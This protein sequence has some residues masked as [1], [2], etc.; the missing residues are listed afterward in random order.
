MNNVYSCRKI[1]KLLRRDI[2]FIWLANYEKP[3]YITINRFR[4]RV[5]NELNEIFTLLVLL[6]AEKGFITLDVEYIDG[7]KLESRANKYTFW[8]KGVER[9]RHKLQEKIAVLLDQIDESVTQENA[10]QEGEVEFTPEMV[11]HIAS[12]LKHS[13]ETSPAPA[14]KE[15]KARMRQKKRQVKELE[16][17]SLKLQEYDSRLAAMGERNSMSKTDP[18]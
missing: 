3:D 2:H 16:K 11:R 7:T 14:T 4:C 17:H 18:P 13:L 10:L 8:K 5:K 15:D 9:N 1:E 6:P 12:E